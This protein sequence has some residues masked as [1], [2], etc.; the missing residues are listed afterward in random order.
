MWKLI[1]AAIPVQLLEMEMRCEDVRGAEHKEE[2]WVR[3]RAP[4]PLP[5]D[6]GVCIR[7]PGSPGPAAGINKSPSP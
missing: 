6:T 7:R 4:G 5:S 3:P 2:P 1:G